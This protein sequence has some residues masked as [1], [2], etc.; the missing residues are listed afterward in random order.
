GWEVLAGQLPAAVLPFTERVADAPPPD[1]SPQHLA[2]VMYT[3]GSS[4][5]P[6]GVALPHAGL[7]A[8]LQF[9]REQMKIGPGDRVLQFASF[10]FDL[11]V[12]ETFAALTSGATLVLG[13]REDLLPG[14]SLHGLMR[15]QG[16]TLAVLTPS[17]LQILP[18]EGLDTLRV[19]VASAEKLTGEIVTRW[20]RPGRRFF[21]AYGPTEATIVQTIWEAPA[22]GPFPDNPPIGRPTPGVEVHLLGEDGRPVKGRESGE[23]CLAGV[24][25]ARGDGNRPRLTRAQFVT[26]PLGAGGEPVRGRR[27]VDRRPRRP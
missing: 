12:W 26:L 19:V 23:L 21:N 5:Q 15:R 14:P 27:A 16:V 24:C 8:L 2:Y 13:K 7:P 17:V 22:T 3:S 20:Q 18:P 25:L 1:V 4:G 10:T 6:K 9:T 11:S